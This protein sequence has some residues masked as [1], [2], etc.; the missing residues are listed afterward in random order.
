MTTSSN[1]EGNRALL[2][3]YLDL[4][5][6][7]GITLDLLAKDSILAQKGYKIHY[8]VD[9][10]EMYSFSYRKD[11]DQIV[12]AY[13]DEEQAERDIRARM[14]LGYIFSHTFHRLV[15]L[16][17]YVAEFTD[18]LKRV[19]ANLAERTVRG[20]E[21]L[22]R[23]SREPL[24]PDIQEILRRVKNS[25]E[26]LRPEEA[27]KISRFAADHFGDLYAWIQANELI[28][29]IQP[30]QDLIRSKKVIPVI[31]YFTDVQISDKDV[32]NRGHDLYEPIFLKR[33]RTR[34]PQS[35]M[36]AVACAYVESYNTH[37]KNE[38]K[39]LVLITHSKSV[40]QAI[41]Q[42]KSITIEGVKLPYIRNLDYFLT[43]LIYRGSED[44]D[45]IKKLIG[46]LKQVRNSIEKIKDEIDAVKEASKWIYELKTKIE[47]KI[48][49]E[50]AL[51]KPDVEA[52]KLAMAR[53]LIDIFNKN[54]GVI[55][56]IRKKTVSI[57]HEI[58]DSNRRLDTVASIMNPEITR[59][60]QRH[61]EVSTQHLQLSY[62]PT[63]PPVC[64]T[65]SYPMVRKLSNLQQQQKLDDVALKKTFV[66]LVTEAEEAE[67]CLLQAYVACLESDLPKARTHLDRGLGLANLPAEEKRDLLLFKC[68]LLRRTAPCQDTFDECF[69][70]WSAW[71]DDPGFNRLMAL[72]IWQALQQALQN[73]DTNDLGHIEDIL[74]NDQKYVKVML[75]N[76]TVVDIDLAIK[77]A[78][79]AER[80][81]DMHN[82]LKGQVFNTLAYL[83]AEKAIQQNDPHYLRLAHEYTSKLR[84]V[85]R[86][87]DWI[88]R[89]Y[90]TRGYVCLFMAKA[91]QDTAKKQ[92]LLL[93][94]VSDFKKALKD[95][96][97]EFEGE[98]IQKHLEMAEKEL[99]AL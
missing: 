83:Y 6:R 21:E 10:A 9:F 36:D 81:Q 73:K 87:E 24:P 59:S 8:A 26:T 14:A 50:L 70:G 99:N 80:S 22:K 27:E 19:R 92:Q 15:L 33:K 4:V 32:F 49:L 61:S 54:E 63:E 82:T 68:H 46:E 60:I 98:I 1:Q 53:L 65:A 30:M 40:D 96:H 88:G 76:N 79:R 28:D 42:S 38:G 93:E 17:P 37:L 11:L 86:E 29:T 47:Q 23:R 39:Y 66:D 7:L 85:I 34:S 48:N 25:T 58:S 51:A 62:I 41:G 91:E 35:Y 74:R 97:P 56:N 12:D 90:D 18:H 44:K 94:A 71:D 78:L 55:E 16:P 43:L 67:T 89:F 5:H 3:Q 64:L 72:V 13:P 75:R 69:E 84:A 31:E 2:N 57:L 20:E 77:H 52:E 45:Q 95:E